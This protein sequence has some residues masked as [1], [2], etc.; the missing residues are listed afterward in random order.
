M[1]LDAVT[2]AKFYED[3]NK[4]KKDL[5]HLGSIRPKDLFNLP[6]EAQE[7]FMR[8]PVKFFKRYKKLTGK[9]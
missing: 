2:V 5:K 4:G 8:D 3:M 9:F 7:L 1:R 6:P